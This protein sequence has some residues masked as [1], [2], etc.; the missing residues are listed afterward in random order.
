MSGLISCV[1]RPDLTSFL[2]SGMV[3]NG[4]SK[5]VSSK[6]QTA[7]QSPIEKHFLVFSRLCPA[8]TLRAGR[9]LSTGRE[10]CT[11]PVFRLEVFVCVTVQSCSFI[12]TFGSTA[13]VS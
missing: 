5:N 13:R 6:K 4:D 12:L 11:L 3:F 7:P 8:T 1:M 2:S 10:S 9:A